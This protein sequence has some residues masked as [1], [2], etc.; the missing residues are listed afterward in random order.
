MPNSTKKQSLKARFEKMKAR[1]LMKH[2]WAKRIPPRAFDKTWLASE[3]DTKDDKG[4]QPLPM[5]RDRSSYRARDS[6]KPLSLVEDGPGNLDA[7]ENVAEAKPSAIES[8]SSTGSSSAREAS[9]PPATSTTTKS[10]LPPENAQRPW[11]RV[12]ENLPIMKLGERGRLAFLASTY[13]SAESRAGLTKAGEP[14]MSWE[15]VQAAVRES[16]PWKR[17]FHD[18]E[19]TEETPRPAKMSRFEERTA[20]VKVYAPPKNMYTTYHPTKPRRKH[21]FLT[22][23]E[24]ELHRQ[25]KRRY[26]GPPSIFGPSRTLATGDAISQ[27]FRPLKLSPFDAKGDESPHQES[28]VADWS[29]T[30]DY[31]TPAVPKPEVES[32]LPPA[33]A[34]VSKIS[35]AVKKSTSSV[36]KVQIRRSPPPTPAD[37]SAIEP[38]FQP[39]QD[40]QISIPESP[41]AAES[42]NDDSSNKESEDPI[43]SSFKNRR[44]NIRARARNYLRLARFRARRSNDKCLVKVMT[45]SK[46]M[47]EELGPIKHTGTRPPPSIPDDDSNNDN[48]DEEVYSPPENIKDQIELS[49]SIVEKI[50][51]SGTE[52]EVRE[53]SRNDREVLIKRVLRYLPAKESPLKRS[54][55]ESVSE[56]ESE[57]ES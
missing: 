19:E 18:D 2:I 8:S 42:V 35:V 25:K 4:I 40:R 9:L 44:G 6:E 5:A 55:L 23:D 30:L 3:L 14:E 15:E 37:T 43:L 36:P 38:S 7:A 54:V 24:E 53:E 56:S 22:D 28:K 29:V 1:H 31:P 13:S 12:Y 49:H 46:R 27:I 41:P 47:K 16:P 48:K 17:K 39:P 11:K 26:D 33:H 32:S 10:L 45:E 34:V 52:N 20:T 21:A 57:S 51:Q 50:T